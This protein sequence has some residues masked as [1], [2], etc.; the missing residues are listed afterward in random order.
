MEVPRQRHLSPAPS[1]SPSTPPHSPGDP[2][3]TNGQPGLG[4][5]TGSQGHRVGSPSLSVCWHQ[6][7]IRVVG[8]TGGFSQ[9]IRVHR[10]G[11]ALNQNELTIGLRRV[12]EGAGMAP[13]G[14]GKLVELQAGDRTVGNTAAKQVVQPG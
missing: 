14:S 5:V 13:G 6:C 12:L 9:S 8:A 10:L 4:R 2:Q 11:S 7:V 1:H 3:T